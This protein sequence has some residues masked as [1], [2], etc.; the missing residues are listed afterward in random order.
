MDK[1]KMLE[2]EH[3]RTGFSS[4]HVLD[5]VIRMY[6]ISLHLKKFSP[7]HEIFNQKIGEILA[8]GLVDAMSKAMVREQS[9]SNFEDIGPQVLTMDHLGVGFLAWLIPFM[10]SLIA[11]S[12]EMLIWHSKETLRT[13][14]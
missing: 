4:L 14:E 7:F 12:F 5:E 6:S 2:K 3:Y 13:R 8:S 1:I 10:C 11:F 9:K